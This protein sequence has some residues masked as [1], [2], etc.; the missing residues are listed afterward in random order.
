MRFTGEGRMRATVFVRRLYREY[1]KNGVA[2]AAAALSYYFV[3]AL[4]PF[5]FFLTTLTAYLP[6]VRTAVTTMLDRARAIVPAQA[7][8]L[9]DT[10]VRELVMNQRPHLLTVGIAVTLYLTSRG[11]DACR[12][13]L[14]QAYDVKESRPFWRRELLALG[15]TIGGALLL[16]IGVT[17]LVAGGDAGLWLA[18]RLHLA[19]EY[20]TLWRWLSWPITAG[21]V[22]TL[23]ALSY[24][25]LPNVGARKFRLVTPGSVLGTVTWL[26]ATWGF[27]QYVAHF[28]RYNITYGSI[29]GV[30]VLMTWFYITGFLFLMGG[31]LNS[32][33]ESNERDRGSI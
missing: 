4:F 12:K 5:L 8:G 3:F 2:D 29:G 15:M 19:K 13:A 32:L 24:H 6:S 28:G 33:V 16:L 7:M 25:L 18:G 17:A 11:V 26:A 30:I 27:T 22:M 23:S 14:N 10:H 20:V 31:E 1:E 21:A 9:I